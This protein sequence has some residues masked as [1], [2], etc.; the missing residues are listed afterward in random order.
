MLDLGLNNESITFEVA[1]EALG[2]GKQPFISALRAEKAK[3]NPC[4]AFIRFCE[5]RKEAISEL[6][7]ALRPGDT[8]TIRMILDQQRPFFGG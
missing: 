8:D 3:P 1:L 2:Q 6:Q 4:A 5:M 7:D